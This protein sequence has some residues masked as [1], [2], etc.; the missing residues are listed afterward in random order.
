MPINSIWIAKLKEARAT[1]PMTTFLLV[2]LGTIIAAT[3]L[4]GTLLLRLSLDDA[5]FWLKV[6][7]AVLAALIFSVGLAALITGHI[8]GEAQREKTLTLEKGNIESQR[9]LET[10]RTKRL[11]LERSIA[12]R[13][14]PLFE[15]GGKS[16]I[17]PLRPFAGVEMIVWYFPDDES[18][19]AA[20]NIDALAKRAGWKLAKAAANPKLGHSFFDG[21]VVEPHFSPGQGDTDTAADALVE[22]LRANNWVVRKWTDEAS[23]VPQNTVRISVGL[24]PT[25]YFLNKEM[26]DAWNLRWTTKPPLR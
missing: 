16:N 21:V 2:L 9:A 6:L 22:F 18:Q 17:D 13:Y 23:T 15:S 14:V 4:L 10:E 5:D 19:R 12:P 26:R 11:E 1:K 8:T 25:P 7:S 20:G 24:K 3:L